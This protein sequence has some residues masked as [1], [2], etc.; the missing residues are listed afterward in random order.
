MG[1]CS[2]QELNC[3][4]NWI[5]V[6]RLSSSRGGLLADTGKKTE[7]VAALFLGA[8]GGDSSQKFNLSN[9]IIFKGIY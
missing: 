1:F 7:E 6:L 9:K 2:V 5:V 3:V 4:F 8:E